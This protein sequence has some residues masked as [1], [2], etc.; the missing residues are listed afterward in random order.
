M[1]VQ[2]PFEAM[3]T[4]TKLGKSLHRKSLNRKTLSAL[5]WAHSVNSA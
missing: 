5:Y 2:S 1:S 3:Q 4:G